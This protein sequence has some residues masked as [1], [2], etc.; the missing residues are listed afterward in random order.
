MHSLNKEFQETESQDGFC[1]NPKLGLVFILILHVQK[2]VLRYEI[3]M[4]QNIFW[5]SDKDLIHFFIKIY[6]IINK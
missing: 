1:D 6:S 5:K 4:L 2:S 3:F